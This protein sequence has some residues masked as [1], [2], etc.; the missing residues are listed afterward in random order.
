MTKLAFEIEDMAEAAHRIWMEGKLRDGWTYA[1]VTDKA[2]KQHSCL[3]PYDQL[4]EADKESDRDLV[5][6]IP[7]ILSAAGYSIVKNR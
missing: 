1:P 5:R 2:A 3:V 6:G 7:D 4:S